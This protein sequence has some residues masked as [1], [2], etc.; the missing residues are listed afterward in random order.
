MN[1]TIETNNKP[2][3]QLI[4]RDAVA[5]A[6]YHHWL[7]AGQPCGRDQE[8]WHRAEA[9]LKAIAAQDTKIVQCPGTKQ[10]AQR[11]E[12]ARSAPALGS[13]KVNGRKARRRL[14]AS[15]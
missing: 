2:K 10:P 8:F 9:Q 15:L 11:P 3:L 4:P 13:A 5:T 12:P 6:A 14:V 7:E 1:R